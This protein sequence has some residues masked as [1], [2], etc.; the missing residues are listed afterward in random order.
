MISRLPKFIKTE[1]ASQIIRQLIRGNTRNQAVKQLSDIFQSKRQRYLIATFLDVVCIVL[2]GIN[3]VEPAGRMIKP[4]VNPIVTSLEEFHPFV[5]IKSTKEKFAFIPSGSTNKSRAMKF[6]GLSAAAYYDIPVTADGSLNRDSRGYNNFEDAGMIF[7]KA[8][9]YN[10]KVLLT[11]SQTNSQVIRRILDSSEAQQTLI[12]ESVSEVKDA[13]IDGVV[14]AFEY[15]ETDS[16]QYKNKFT[17]FIS[18]VTKQMHEKLPDSQVAVALD[19][20]RVGDKYIYDAK[21][22][23]NAADKVYVMAYDF[24][25]PETKEQQPTTPI[26]GYNDGEYWSQVTTSLDTFQKYVPAEKLVLETAWYGNGNNYPLYTPKADVKNV[27]IK[28][29]KVILDYETLNKLVAGVPKKSREAARKNIPHIVK[30]LDDEKILNHNVL[31]YALATIEH[32]TAG[33]FQ[34]IE[35]YYG[36]Q[37]ARRLGYEGGT[38][39]FGRGFIQL[40]HLR[41]YKIIG[42]RIGMGEDLVKKPELASEPEVAAKILA[43]FFKDN[44]IATLASQGKFVAARMPVN[45]DRNGSKVAQ[46]AAKYE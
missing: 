46:L 31:A 11:L 39:Y 9:A 34:P 41:N 21:A 16:G 2:I 18:N 7:E 24:A 38:N 40:T 29:E 5:S 19:G 45:P 8:H 13:G 15:G 27:E 20:S 12:D 35:E 23:G 1:K 6:N 28:Q 14:I 30:A 17:S 32:E 3:A 22:L 26:Y 10:T 4:L 43:A 25:V 33:T 42:E 44:N 36:R 37:S